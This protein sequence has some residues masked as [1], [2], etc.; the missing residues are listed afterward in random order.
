MRTKKIEPSNLTAQEK[1]DHHLQESHAIQKIKPLRS[2]AHA[3]WQRKT[4]ARSARLKKKIR[5]NRGRHGRG[6]TNRVLA[7]TRNHERNQKE[8]RDRELMAV[9]KSNKDCCA[10]GRHLRAGRLNAAWVN[11]RW[12]RAGKSEQRENFL[13]AWPLEQEGR[14]GIALCT[15]FASSRK[16]RRALWTWADIENWTGNKIHETKSTAR[17]MEWERKNPSGA[18]ERTTD[19]FDGRGKMDLEQK[20]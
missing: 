10:R 18:L 6:I 16:I 19:G 20:N 17:D 14:K 4:T 3:Q 15:G 2:S 7:G 1:T 9:E 13:A 5:T 12:N 8:S 11:Q